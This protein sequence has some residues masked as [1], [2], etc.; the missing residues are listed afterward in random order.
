MLSPAGLTRLSLSPVRLNSGT[1]HR[2][3]C[4]AAGGD[5]DARE[6]AWSYITLLF[7]VIKTSTSHSSLI[8][9]FFSL[10][11]P[12][13]WRT[14]FGYRRGGEE[15]GGPAGCSQMEHQGSGSSG[16]TADPE[17]MTLVDGRCSPVRTVHKVFLFFYAVM[18]FFPALLSRTL[19][20]VNV[21]GTIENVQIL[22]CRFVNGGVS[23]TKRE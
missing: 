17:W 21:R 9:F 15:A 7:P 6:A 8:F 13:D 3:A 2:R 11:H 10:F 19:R 12:P 18:Y 1:W 5:A 14:E 23:S 22:W 16:R 20:W 4:P